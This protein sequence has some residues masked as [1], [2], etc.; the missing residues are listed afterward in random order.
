MDKVFKLLK[1]LP[2]LMKGNVL[3]LIFVVLKLTHVID[4][5]WWLVTILLWLPVAFLLGIVSLLIL[6]G[7]MAAVFG[8]KVATENE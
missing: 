7:I 3:T 8:K 4:W 1:V 5:S 6:G 2:Y